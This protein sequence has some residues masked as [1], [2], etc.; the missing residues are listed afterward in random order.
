MMEAHQR[1][2][3]LLLPSMAML[4]AFVVVNA[5]IWLLLPMPPQYNSCDGPRPPGYT[6]HLHAFRVP[7]YAL[8]G[9]LGVA[10]GAWL[11]WTSFDRRGDR[12]GWPTTVLVALAAAGAFAALLS[13]YVRSAWALLGIVGFLAGLAVIPGLLVWLLVLAVG[14]PRPRGSLWHGRTTAWFLIYLAL[15]AV[16][17]I[18]WLPGSGFQLEC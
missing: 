7:A 2:R 8:I 13:D 17:L 16:A 15:P 3:D 1:R 6:A 12:P 18:A 9:L 14:R 4:G 11:L 10:A 5:V